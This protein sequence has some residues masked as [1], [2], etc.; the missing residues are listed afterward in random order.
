MLPRNAFFQGEKGAWKIHPRESE[1]YKKVISDTNYRE[2]VECGGKRS[3][4]PLWGRRQ[5]FQR[6][7]ELRDGPK[8]FRLLHHQHFNG[9][10]GGDQFDA[11]LL[12]QRA[13]KGARV[14]FPRLRV[15]LH[16]QVITA[17]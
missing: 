16:L 12:S 4:T 14:R 8:L 11:Q 2:V 6:D 13:L 15:P 10:V 3:A 17:G 7:F 5:K 1:S 9:H